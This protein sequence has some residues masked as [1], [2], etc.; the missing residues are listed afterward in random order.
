MS[1]KQP[2]SADELVND[3]LSGPVSLPQEYPEG[4]A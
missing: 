2:S 4:T 3:L 1:Q